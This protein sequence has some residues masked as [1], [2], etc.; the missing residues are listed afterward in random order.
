MSVESANDHTA[1]NKK[2]RP[3]RVSRVP[4][5]IEGVHAQFTAR[6]ITVLAQ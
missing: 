2:A 1:G 6:R 3:K 4:S 5:G